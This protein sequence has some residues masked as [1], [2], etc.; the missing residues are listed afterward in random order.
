MLVNS[1]LF[2]TDVNLG[3]PDDPSTTTYP[4]GNGDLVM[5]IEQT[6]GAVDVSVTMIYETVGA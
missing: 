4:S 1:T 5:L 2:Q 6:A 3:G